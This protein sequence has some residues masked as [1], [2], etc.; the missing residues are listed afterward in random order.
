MVNPPVKASTLMAAADVRTV[1]QELIHQSHELQGAPQIRLLESALRLAEVAQDDGL[2]RTIHFE[3]IRA[4]VQTRQIPKLL[5]SVAWLK[6]RSHEPGDTKLT[7]VLYP[8]VIQQL[9][10]F[11][12]LPLKDIQ[13]SLSELDRDLRLTRNGEFR[14]VYVQWAV[15]WDLGQIDRAIDLYREFQKY[16]LQ[17]GGEWP[18]EACA[19]LARVKFQIFLGNDQEAI[20]MAGPLRHQRVTCERDFQV[21]V[22]TT[23]ML[24]LLRLGRSAEAVQY[25][26]LTVKRLHSQVERILLVQPHIAFLCLTGNNAAAIKLFEHYLPEVFNSPLG[27]ERLHFWMIGIQL[28]RQL[29]RQKQAQL[30]LYLPPGCPISTGRDFYSIQALLDWMLAEAINLAEKFDFRNGNDFYQR[31]LNQLPEFEVTQ[32]PIPLPSKPQSADSRRQAL[33]PL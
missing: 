7:N 12:N 26:L 23:L 17:A 27:L 29:L 4:L 5:A 10:Q 22:L 31:Q 18:C 21:K 6:A 2:S 14:S 30:F 9:P 33:P 8:F 25:H 24:P 13:T 15:N 20:E 19:L 11:H 28:F 1:V 16:S 3:L 32:V